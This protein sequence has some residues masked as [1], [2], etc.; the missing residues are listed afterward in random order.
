MKAAKFLTILQLGLAH[1]PE[2]EVNADQESFY[3]GGPPASSEAGKALVD[4]GALWSD[5]YDCWMVFL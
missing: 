5:E 4:L 3:F 1:E 2:G